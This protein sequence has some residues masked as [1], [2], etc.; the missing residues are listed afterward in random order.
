MIGIVTPG[1]SRLDFDASV[2]GGIFP[3]RIE[4]CRDPGV[5][6]WLETV[7]KVLPI[8]PRPDGYDPLGEKNLD[9]AWIARLGRTG[10]NCYDA[11]VRRDAR[12]LGASMNE[13]MLCWETILPNVVRH[14]SISADLPGLLAYYQARSHGAMYSGCGG[15]YLY[16]VSQEPVAGAFAVQ[17]RTG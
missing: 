1:V 4:T 11:I 16:V 5:A 3:S 13:C 9:P 14:P 8:A 7:V 17:V 2:E 6:R 10:R 12:G 15:G